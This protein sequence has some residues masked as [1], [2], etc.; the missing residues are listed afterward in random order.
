MEST[1]RIDSSESDSDSRTTTPN[2]MIFE[3][4]LWTERPKYK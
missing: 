4:A 2:K 3:S 1:E